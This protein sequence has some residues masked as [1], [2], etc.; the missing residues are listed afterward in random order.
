MSG[1][2]QHYIP[3]F[4][5][6]GFSVAGSH[7][8]KIWKIHKG[9]WLPTKPGS[10][11]RI[12]SESCFYSKPSADGLCTLDDEITNEENS[13][14]A[15]L[16]SLRGA[17][18]GASVNSVDA[19]ELVCH[20]S[21]RTAHL[22]EVFERGMRQI[23]VGAAK[24][25]TDADRV[26]SMIGIDQQE[27]N[28]A[29]RT[30]VVSAL[31]KDGLL[32][33]LP[34][35]EAVV[36][37][38][39][40]HMGKEQFQNNFDKNL[41][42]MKEAFS[43]FLDRTG[44]TVRSGHNKALSK[45]GGPGKRRELLRIFRWEI[46]AA[47]REGAVLPDCVAMAIDR[48]EGVTPFMLARNDDCR[49]VVMPLD[50]CLLLLG[51]CGGFKLPPDFNY[52]R[53]AAR[54]SHNF[55]LASSNREEVQ[56]LQSVIGERSSAKID[57]S[58]QESLSKFLQSAS[59]SCYRREEV[60]EETPSWREKWATQYPLGFKVSVECA[61]E[62]T[63][64]SIGDKVGQLANVIG[65]SLPMNRLEAVTFAFDY[66]KALREVDLGMSDLPQPTTTDGKVGR[67][68]G[69]E[70]LVVRDGIIKSQIVMD[71]CVSNSL[72]SEEV[73]HNLWASSAIAQQLV[74]VSLTEIVDE[75]LP[76][77]LLRPAP[78]YY[79]GVLYGPVAGAALGYISAYLCAG[80]G[81]P[82]QKVADSRQL[83]TDSLHHMHE[84]VLSA[85]LAYRSHGDV[86][87]LLGV[88]FPLIRNV[89]MF[90]SDL[91]G[92]AS[93]LEAEVTPSG[94]AL[95]GALKKT[96]LNFWL[97]CY[98]ADLD[99]FRLRLGAWESFDEFTAFIVHVERVMW[100]LGMIP[101]KDG[102]GVRVEIPL[103]SDAEALMADLV[104]AGMKDGTSG[105][106]N[107]ATD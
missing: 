44:E 82:E 30:H 34:L 98:K 33:S 21:P 46:I 47:P 63:A 45:Q 72:I 103:G 29:F 66:P 59:K 51:V 89:L 15:I 100:Q 28:E 9:D 85:R 65:Q 91:L 77:G 106:G 71:S 13:I 38:I 56:K 18:V 107:E 16:Q 101:W 22:R 49:A 50:E 26:K 52:N 42:S 58:V 61:D 93:A 20:F 40:F 84:T 14:A 23:V 11:N 62:T 95:E 53:E 39:A 73:G 102:E 36:E 10:I 94:S 54:A 87:K 37:R 8:K 97:S 88:T 69:K 96:G 31:R 25:L 19:S 12:A 68:I 99:R 17:G 1:K 105:G 75:A 41:P 57:E 7:K 2:N 90:A 60:V 76:G 86:D 4:L 27:P 5:Q 6:R 64:K 79:T 80:F 32:A 55:F 43:N 48:E 24:V 67:G 3:Q 83:L 74:N 104:A 78:D 70:V 81:D 92:Q 35:P